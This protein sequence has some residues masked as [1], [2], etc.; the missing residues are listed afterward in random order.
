MLNNVRISEE[1]LYEL[2]IKTRQ[3]VEKDLESL[4]A[5]MEKTNVYPKVMWDICRKNDLFRLSLP[6]Q[7]GGMGLC[8][9][10]YF[11]VLEEIGRGNQ[12]IRMYL[13]VAN[14]L[15]WEI[16]AEHGGDELKN[17]YLSKMGTGEFFVAFALTEPGCGSGVDIRSTAE[18]KGDKYILNGQKTL[19]SF[20]DVCDAYYII[21]VT[22]ESKR[23]KGGHTAFYIPADAPGLRVENMPHMMGCRGTGHGDVFLENCEVPEKY[24]LGAEG[25]GLTIFLNALAVS[26]ASIGVCLLGMSQKFLEM[27]IARA[28]DRI[29]FGK[30]LIQRQ[31]IQQS[32]AD[33]ATQVHVLRLLARDC[34]QKADRGQD[35]EMIS[36]MLKLH[37][38]DTVRTVSDAC[39]EIFGGIGYFEDNPYGPVERLYRDARAMWFEEGP[40]TVQRLTLVRDVIENKGELRT[41]NY[42]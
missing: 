11:T 25:E 29:T 2:R 10:Q 18:K 23:K 16:M 42:C 15:S 17:T 22:D 35:I 6:T 41:S 3:A 4:S 31:A 32:I 19:I 39:L 14:G 24:R 9:E 21:A 28:N 37:A 30:P 26:R 5:E 34:A 7:Y 38:I 40:R 8:L 27:A 36:S 33:M 1:E 12:A 13:H 20:T